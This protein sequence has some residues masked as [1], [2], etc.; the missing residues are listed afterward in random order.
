MKEK[1][2]SNRLIITS[3]PKGL[4][5][6]YVWYDMRLNFVDSEKELLKQQR[7]NKI[8]KILKK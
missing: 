1:N 2:E 5:T 8:K 4:V 6:G 7:S 3:D